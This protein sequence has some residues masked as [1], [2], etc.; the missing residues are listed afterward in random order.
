M[1]GLQQGREAQAEE[2]DSAPSMVVGGKE[3]ATCH[4]DV[5]EKGT[6]SGVSAL[7]HSG[8]EY[9]AALSPSGKMSEMQTLLPRPRSNQNLHF[10]KFPDNLY[11]HESQKFYNETEKGTLLKG[12]A[13]S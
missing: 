9:P 10:N 2:S 13:S 4:L 8:L 12:V 1:G 5:N 7:R 3:A 11:A 6:S